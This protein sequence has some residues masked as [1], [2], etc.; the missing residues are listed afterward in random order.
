M[1]KLAQWPRFPSKVD[2]VSCMD[3]FR[4]L[5][6]KLNKVDDEIKLILSSA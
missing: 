5:L 2:I 6:T 1:K 3:T 4:G